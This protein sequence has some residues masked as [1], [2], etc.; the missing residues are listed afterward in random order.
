MLAGRRRRA[1]VPDARWA[2]DT[3]KFE[4]AREFGVARR[5]ETGPVI[6]DAV[7]YGRLLDRFK[8]QIAEEL[9]LDQKV[10]HLGWAS[11]PT[12]E[13]GAVGGRLGGQI[14]GQMVRRMIALAEERLS[15]GGGLPPGSPAATRPDLPGPGRAGTG[16]WG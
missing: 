10:R 13:C 7:S 1:L 4:V 11:M 5:P 15:R 9:G 2:L 14:G 12:R 8:W 16:G 6:T 3:F